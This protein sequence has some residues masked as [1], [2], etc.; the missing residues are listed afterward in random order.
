MLD[1]KKSLFL[2][3]CEM[4]IVVWRGEISGAPNRLYLWQVNNLSNHCK[5][6]VNKKKK[7]N[8][9]PSLRRI[10]FPFRQPALT[11]QV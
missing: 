2:K 8:Y 3:I 10:L 11:E 9:H 4:Y 1:K 5:E 6:E 7:G